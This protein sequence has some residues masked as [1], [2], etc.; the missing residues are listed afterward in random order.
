MSN[1]TGTLTSEQ[2]EKRGLQQILHVGKNSVQKKII[3]FFFSDLKGC[4]EPIS[5]MDVQAYQTLVQERIDSLDTKQM[6]FK[7]LGIDEEEVREIT[8]VCFGGYVFNDNVDNLVAQA[9]SDFWV[10]SDY[11]ITWIFFSEYEVFVYQYTFS[12]IS[13]SEKENTM[14]FSY[15]DITSF[16]ASSEIYQKFVTISAGCL[17][18][19]STRQ[20]SAKSN[21]FKIVVPGDDFRCWITP[22]ENTDATIHG[23][24]NKLR[25]MKNR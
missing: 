1:L 24:R 17:G 20:V 7:K 18:K 19:S 13:D 8:P 2:A 9:S 25:E 14:Q 3:N 4:L 22:D 23:M 11:T 15:K 21:M 10:S 16:T 5:G 12:M 6:A